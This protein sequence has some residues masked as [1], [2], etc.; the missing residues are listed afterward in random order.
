MI[1]HS[2]KKLQTYVKFVFF[3]NKLSDD[4]RAKII[5]HFSYKTPCRFI[6]GRF[7]KKKNNLT[8]FLIN[9]IISGLV[10]ACASAHLT[11]ALKSAFDTTY[12]GLALHKVRSLGRS[13]KRLRS[14]RRSYRKESN[15][16]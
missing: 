5:K 6:L 9:L 2:N 7:F 3:N 15:T 1:I 16:K 11:I 8:T 14:L 13:N 12:S 4:L 10:K